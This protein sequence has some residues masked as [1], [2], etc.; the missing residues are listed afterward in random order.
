MI[1]CGKCSSEFD[2]SKNDGCPM[3]RFGSKDW[4]GETVT[5]KEKITQPTKTNYLAIPGDLK[6]KSGKPIGDDWGSWGMFNSFFP[7]KAVLR[8]LA[9]M[10]HENKAESIKLYDLVSKTI[11]VF[12][13]NGFSKLRGFPS[14]PKKDNSINR[15][16]YTALRY[17]QACCDHC[18]PGK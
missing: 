4:S 17:Q 7:G 12:K 10:L 2:L 11:D 1:K 8:V 16:V 15:L 18:G 9:N 14:N 5:K 3:C 6:L 13:E